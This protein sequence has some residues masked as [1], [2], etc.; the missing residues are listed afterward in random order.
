[1]QKNKAV[2]PGRAEMFTEKHDNENKIIDLSFL[3]P[4]ESKL[5]L[6]VKHAYYMTKLWITRLDLDF[7]LSNIQKHDW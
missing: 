1:M 6:H 5:L 3:P 7:T 2:N 4:Y